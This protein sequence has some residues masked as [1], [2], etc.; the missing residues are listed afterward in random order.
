[1]TRK[2]NKEARRVR[3]LAGLEELSKMDRF[4][5]IQVQKGW[6]VVRDRA[7]RAS[8]VLTTLE[9]AI[10]VANVI[11]RNQSADAVVVHN[12]DGSIREWQDL[13]D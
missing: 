5:V 9:E 2:S 6:A 12:A 4:H 13:T 1:M 7:S 10:E 11:A 8:R 3:V